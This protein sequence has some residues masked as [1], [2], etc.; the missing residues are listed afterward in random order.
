MDSEK[1]INEYEFRAIEEIQKKFSKELLP[2]LYPSDYERLKLI[3]I[4]TAKGIYGDDSKTYLQITI[5]EKYD[6]INHCGGQF[7]P[8]FIELWIAL[9]PS[10]KS[11]LNERKMLIPYMGVDKNEG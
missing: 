4:G 11:I 3:G 10:W 6:P 7:F 1:L 5:E 8:I 2:F 9:S